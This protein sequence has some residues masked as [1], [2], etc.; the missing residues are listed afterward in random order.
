[1]PKLSE[2]TLEFIQKEVKMDY[3]TLSAEQYD[4]GKPAYNKSYLKGFRHAMDLYEM[5]FKSACSVAVL[6]DGKGSSDD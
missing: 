5:Y 6:S 2:E 1:M 4:T 3:K